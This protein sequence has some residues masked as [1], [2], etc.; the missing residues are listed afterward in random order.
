MKKQKSIRDRFRKKKSANKVRGH[1]ETS[2][3]KTI[4]SYKSPGEK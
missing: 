1:Q 2:K 4:R 3:R